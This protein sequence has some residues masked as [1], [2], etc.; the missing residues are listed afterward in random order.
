MRIA[1]M[2]SGGVGGYV[3][4]RRTVRWGRRGGICEHRRIALLG[5]CR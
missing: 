2:G 5:R 4:G 1:I 3:G